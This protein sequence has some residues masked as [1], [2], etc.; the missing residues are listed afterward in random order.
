MCSLLPKMV[1]LPVQTSL[2]IKSETLSFHFHA[3]E[4]HKIKAKKYAMLFIRGGGSISPNN[5]TAFFECQ[6]STLIGFGD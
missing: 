6:L 5:A 4:I 2:R 1:Q 3:T